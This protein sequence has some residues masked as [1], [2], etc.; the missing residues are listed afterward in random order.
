MTT[1]LKTLATARKGSDS[2]SKSFWTNHG[3]YLKTENDAGKTNEFIILNSLPCPTMRIGKDGK[4]TGETCYI[5]NC[6]N[7][8]KKE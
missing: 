5:I 3:V 2:T 7:P 4:P 1:K 8:D 6:F